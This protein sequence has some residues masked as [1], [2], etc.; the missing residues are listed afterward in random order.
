MPKSLLIVESPAKARTLGR[1][2]GKD[3][4]VKASVGH[5]KDLPKNKLGIDVEKDFLVQHG[6]DAEDDAA[7]N[8]DGGF[9]VFEREVPRLDFL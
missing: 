2:L 7:G 9:A 1:Y 5:I 8:D 3:F 4:V 6:R